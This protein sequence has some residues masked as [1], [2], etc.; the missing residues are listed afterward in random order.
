MDFVS[1]VRV[2][3]RALTRNKMR[4]ILTMLGIIIGVGAVIAMVGVGQGANEQMQAQIAAMGS[5]LLIIQSGSRQAGVV[6]VGFG[7]TK[8]LVPGDEAAILAQVPVVKEVA[9][10]TGTHQQVISDNN[11]WGTNIQGTEP[12]YFDIRNWNFDL[13]TSFTEQDVAENN[14]VA[15][16]GAT[17]LLNLFPDGSSP[18]GKTIRIKNLPFTVV[19][20][21]QPKG[22][23]GGGQD[24][25]D[26]VYIP[27]TT[28]QKKLS[29][30]NWLSNISVSAVSKDTTDTASQQITNLLHTRHR[31]RAGQPN[32]F[33]VNNLSDVAD[34]A[35]AA[36]SIM[37]ILLG[38]I[39]SV[40]LLVGGIG[41]MN[42]MLVSVTERT[43]EIGIR[44][45]VGATESDVKRQFIIEALV[46]ASIG[47]VIGILFGLVTSW[48]ISAIAKWAVDV[49]IIS[50]VGAA[51]FSAAIGIFFGYY[52]AKKAANLDPIEALRFE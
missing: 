20:T 50:I 32:D 45:A 9:A 47:G 22:Q 36:S 11:N 2:A 30:Q 16:L 52:P 15:V 38:S 29:G 31:I 41:I 42:I 5:N 3:L 18:I 51:L 7:A 33:A 1:I 27:Y 10:G 17:P 14:N 28:L 19:G 44:M 8:T 25:D 40:S 37:T 48:L 4:S 43:R 12:T 34:V 23:S 24:Q 35:S 13:G 46:L 39:A 6:H 26:N 49:S 21:L